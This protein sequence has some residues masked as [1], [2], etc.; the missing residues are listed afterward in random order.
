MP[1]LRGMERTLRISITMRRS[2]LTGS[3]K[4]G[5]PKGRAALSPAGGD[6]VYFPFGYAARQLALRRIGLLFDYI[7]IT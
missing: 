1:Q 6:D 3:E 4:I 5:F 2:I 7:T